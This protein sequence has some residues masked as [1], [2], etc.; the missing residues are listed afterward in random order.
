MLE[1]NASNRLTR[2]QDLSGLAAI[3]AICLVVSG[4]GGWVTAGSVGSWYPTLNKPAFNPPNWVFA[5]IWTALYLMMAF[6]AWRVWRS[7]ATPTRRRALVVFGAQLMLN[8]FWSLLFFGGQQI[9]WAL[10]DILALLDFIAVNLV[11]FWRVERPA[12][13]LLIP[14]L[15]W[16]AFAALLNASLWSL[17]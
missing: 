5:P 15:L 12:G 14:Y 16:V 8:L 2:R 7:P 9:A 13:L 11:L 4:I 10:V 3:L 6:A 17:N 1:Q